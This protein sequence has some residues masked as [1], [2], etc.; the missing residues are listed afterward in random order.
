MSVLKGPAAAALY[1]SR[2][3]N[4]VILVTTKSGKSGVVEVNVASRFS[5]SW[6]TNLPEVQRQY[7]RGYMEEQYDKDGNYVSTN[8]ND[9]AYT[10]W[11]QKSN[12]KTSTKPPNKWSRNK[13]GRSLKAKE[14]LVAELGKQQLVE[15]EI[16]VGDPMDL[17]Q[18]EKRRRNKAEGSNFA[19]LVPGRVL[20]DQHRPQQ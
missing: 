7:T 14:S 15:V 17:C 19:T 3:A 13:G 5:T 8:F 6:V 20:E 10:S 16:S 11:G 9:F 1:G 2:A 12:A 4:G 18:G